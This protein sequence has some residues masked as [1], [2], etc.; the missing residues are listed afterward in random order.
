VL[1]KT[2]KVIAKLGDVDGLDEN[3]IARSFA[4]PAS[5]AF[6]LDGKTLYVPNLT[7]FLALCRRA[8]RR[9][10]AMDAAG[11]ALHGCR[12]CAPWSR[13]STAMIIDVR[14]DAPR[15]SGASG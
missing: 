6:S 14:C 4:F 9:R 7:L 1:D 11:K 12:S 13:R 15:E 3:G 2:G 5:L 8:G 10:F